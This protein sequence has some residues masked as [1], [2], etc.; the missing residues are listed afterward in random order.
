[1]NAHHS[2]FIVEYSN[3][4]CHHGNEF[5]KLSRSSII[6]CTFLKKS[7]LSPLMVC[8][9]AFVNK[10]SIVRHV[11]IIFCDFPLKNT[12]KWAM[13]VSHIKFN[14]SNYYF[15][16]S[17]QTIDLTSWILNS[18]SYVPAKCSKKI[19]LNTNRKQNIP[20]QLDMLEHA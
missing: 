19:L 18:R 2:W 10:S 3:A 7:P 1:M 11:N 17:E 5:P 4:Y 6:Q 14:I 16:S 15:G 12:N 8:M 9:F 13:S 20:K